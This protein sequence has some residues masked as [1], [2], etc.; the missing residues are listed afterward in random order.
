M[1]QRYTF[2]MDG[3]RACTHSWGIYNRTHASF[4]LLCLRAQCPCLRMRDSSART[5]DSHEVIYARF[6]IFCERDY[7]NDA[8]RVH[9]CIHWHAH[10]TDA[11]CMHSV[12]IIDVRMR[13]YLHTYECACMAMKA[14]VLKM[15]IFSDIG[16]YTQSLQSV[17]LPTRL[18]HSSWNQRRRF[19]SE[20]A[21][22]S[23]QAIRGGWR[24]RRRQRHYGKRSERNAV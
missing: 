12:C 4:E 24:M 17:P 21:R 3:A 14:R 19:R 18:Q 10:M 9:V 7:S 8:W 15:H 11:L 22:R 6:I 16:A 23:L 13:N 1:L 2:V 5:C 20:H